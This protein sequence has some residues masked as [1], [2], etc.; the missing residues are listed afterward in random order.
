MFRGGNG[1]APAGGPPAYFFKQGIQK[2]RPVAHRLEP[3]ITPGNIL[4]IDDAYN[5][6]SDSAR[7]AI[8]VLARF[9]D[10]RKI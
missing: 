1:G 9:K 10:R 6:N 5:G 8:K 3:S 2:I 4:V 7:E